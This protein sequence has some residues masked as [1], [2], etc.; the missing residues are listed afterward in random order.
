M[1]SFL[2]EK[3]NYSLATAG[4]RGKLYIHLSSAL[5]VPVAG[6]SADR[7]CRFLSAGRMLVQAVGL[8][9]G[10]GFVVLVARST[11]TGL[12]LLGMS[13]FGVCKGFYDSGIFASL[14]DVIE[15]DRRGIGAGLMNTIGWAGGALGPLLVGLLA[16]Y[17]G[18]PTMAQNMSDAMAM[19]SWVYAAAAACV[20][21]AMWVHVRRNPQ[22]AKGV[23][24]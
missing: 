5:V 9:L 17:G 16:K 7:L 14:Y 13:L 2:V 11:S 3:F 24:L 10:A 1:P 23:G 12:L 18:K 4:L 19:G 21:G 22:P 15:A 6:W 20:V 8:M